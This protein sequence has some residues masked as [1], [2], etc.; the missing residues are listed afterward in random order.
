MIR[1]VFILTICRWVSAEWMLT[2]IH[3]FYN[4][5]VGVKTSQNYLDIVANN[6]ANVST[7]GYKQQTA[8][9]YDL[10]Y[11]NMEKA[12]R[13]DA[14][15]IKG[16]G[17]KVEHTGVNWDGGVLIETGSP[18]HYAINGSGFFMVRDPATDE[19][20]LTRDGN[21]M[22]SRQGNGTMY[23][24]TQNG[25][26]VLDSSKRPIVVEEEGAVLPVGV[27]HVDNTG[28]LELCGGNSYRTTDRSG[29]PVSIDSNAVVQGYIEGSNVQLSSEMV[30]MI[31]SQRAYQ[32]NLRMVQTSDEIIQTINNLR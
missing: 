1:A 10:I 7:D 19:E 5:A 18:L 9:V 26:Q 11:T 15:I 27:F 28:G 4:S 17:S 23:L 29:D 20:T 30:S 3:S 21:F 2:M 13:E 16:S 14:N 6:I 25:D 8:S 24:C 31:E 12:Q 22:L 32:L